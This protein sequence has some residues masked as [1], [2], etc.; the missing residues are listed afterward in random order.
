M[1]ALIILLAQTK[2]VAVIEIL[3]LLIV[4]AIIGYVTA[5]LYTRS[6][7]NK[8]LK[9]VE[10]EL[11]VSISQISR[12][13]AENSRLQKNLDSLIKENQELILKE[14]ALKVQNK[15]AVIEIERKT[16]K[17]QQAE[18]LLDEKEEELLLIA[19]RR[20]LLDYNSFGTA[21]ENEKD[22]LQMISGIGPSIEEK[23]HALGIF[24]FLQISKFTKNDIDT[25]DTALIYFSGRIERDEWVEQAKEL[26]ISE[27]KKD[28]L[29]D[30]I[31][32]RKSKIYYDRIGIASENEADD[33]TEISGI[34]KWINEKL[35]ALAIFT[36]KQISK[37][38][39]EDVEEVTEAIEF[40]PGRIER[41]EWIYQAKELVRA[42][43]KKADLLK[44]I[45]ERKV[46]ISSYDNFGIAQKHQANNLTLINGISLWIEERLNMLEIYTFEQISRFESKDIEL[47]TEML[48]LPPNRI[49]KEA[50]V[51]QAREF[52]A[53]VRSSRS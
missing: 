35:N 46:I 48:E 41:D 53:K 33:L 13:N 6:V 31:R 24:S 23:L 29:L 8:K 44:R 10:D 28:E 18:Q 1:N 17:K 52:E 14:Q 7:Y 25:I 27:E 12:L 16:L 40:F 34:G 11:E 22:D 30:R 4:A 9:I 5:W 45:Q 36:F 32:A 15:E 47:I 20:H 38:N 3:L 37:F 26:V 49:E 43:G 21:E 2:G 19:Q 39:E 51:P 42:E 50:W